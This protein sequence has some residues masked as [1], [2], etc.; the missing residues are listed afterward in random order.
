MSDTLY[1][2]GPGGGVTGVLGQWAPLPK[3][4]RTESRKR[5]DKLVALMTA[6]GAD[7]DF[8]S[9]S[10]KMRELVRDIVGRL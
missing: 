1:G 5:F 4:T 2:P 7:D 6:H 8:D 3:D 9:A 10:I